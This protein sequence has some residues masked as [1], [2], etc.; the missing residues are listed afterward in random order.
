[1]RMKLNQKKNNRNNGCMKMMFSI[2]R[3]VKL[4][5]D[6][7]FERYARNNSYEYMSSFAL[8]YRC[9]NCQKIYCYSCSNH[10]H[11]GSTPKYVLLNFPSIKKFSHFFFYFD[12]SQHRYCDFCHEKKLNENLMSNYTILEGPDSDSD[13]NANVNLKFEVRSERLNSTT[14]NESISQEQ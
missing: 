14:D 6:G 10:W 11:H 5:S 9:R 12:S 2:V 4:L 3:N 13:T 1:M 8:Q 7:Q